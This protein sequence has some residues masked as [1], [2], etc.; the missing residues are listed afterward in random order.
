MLFLIDLS[1][2]SRKRRFF[3]EVV[4]WGNALRN[5]VRNVQKGTVLFPPKM[6]CYSPVI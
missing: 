3:R 4:L 2:V 6:K 1:A 5:V